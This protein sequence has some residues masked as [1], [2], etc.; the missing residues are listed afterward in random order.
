MS[1]RPA[2]VVSDEVFQRARVLAG[3]VS[4]LERIGVSERDLAK[5]YAGAYMDYV[6]FLE[7]SVE[8]LFLGLLMGRLVHP[9]ATTLV[10]VKSDVVA[11]KLVR[12]DRTYVDWFPFDLTI[13]RANAFLSSGEPF[14]GVSNSDKRTFKQTGL[15]RNALAHQS[16]H[17]LKQFRRELVDGRN[18][19]ASQH[20]PSQYLR[21][22]HNTTQSRLVFHMAQASACVQRIC[23]P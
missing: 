7:R 11:R 14:A 6:T 4:R 23:I 10:T 8:R 1:P 17:A 20:M 16:T 13:K 12:G 15:L 2:S 19:P 5:V 21:G 22:Q 18:L 3:Y 9:R